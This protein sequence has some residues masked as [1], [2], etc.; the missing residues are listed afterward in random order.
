[1]DDY[2]L[3]EREMVDPSGP[4]PH[5][6]QGGS[7]S[8][9]PRPLKRKYRPRAS[10]ACELCRMK[11]AKCDQGQPCR[12]CRDR[13]VP[14]IYRSNS[15]KNF[16][17]VFDKGDLL[18][19]SE[20]SKQDP[21]AVSSVVRERNL[22]GPSQYQQSETFT[23]VQ[24]ESRA[25]IDHTTF[26]ESENETLLA[27]NH[28]NS[29]TEFYGSSSNFVSFNKLL[30]KARQLISKDSDMPTTAEIHSVDPGHFQVSSVDSLDSGTT[31]LQPTSIRTPGLT[32]TAAST[33]PSQ[34]P[35]SVVNLLCDE[36][37]ILPD[38]RPASPVT[39][40]GRALK[41][42]STAPVTP[43]T[44]PT[45]SLCESNAPQQAGTP[46]MQTRAE[47]AQVTAQN[48]SDCFFGNPML[49]E[50]EYVNLYFHNL[51]YVSPF[52]EREIFTARCER[53]IWASSALK[54]LRRNQMH[55]LALYNAVLAV[56]ALT[57]PTD[58]LE[59]GRAE[60]GAPW[61]EDHSNGRKG[62][63]SSIRLSKLY[64]QRARR[65]LGDVFEICSLESAQT[66]LLLSVYCQHALRPHASYMYSGM[67]VRTALAIGV[68]SPSSLQSA[69]TQVASS[70]TWWCI[71][72]HEI[73]INCSSGREITLG[74]PSD[75][76]LP[77]PSS[78]VFSST[79][80]LQS[81]EPSPTFIIFAQVSL[82]AIHRSASLKIYSMEAS[83]EQKSQSAQ[84]LERE[85]TTWKSKL[86][87]WLNPDVVTFKEPEWMS[88]QK[89][90]LEIRFHHIRAFLYRPFLSF[91]AT[92]VKCDHL[93][94]TCVMEAR[95]MIKILHSAFTHRHY[96]R[97]WWYN[98]T[99]V[100]NASTILLHAI[101]LDKSRILSGAGCCKADV[102]EDVNQALQILESMDQMVVA[103]RYAD[104]LRQILEVA[105]QSRSN[106]QNSQPADES[107]NWQNTRSTGS[108]EHPIA[109]QEAHSA[110]F[111]ENIISSQQRTATVQQPQNSI[112]SGE[113]VLASLIND[114]LSNSF[115]APA[116]DMIFG[117][118]EGWNVAGNLFSD[119]TFTG[120]N[121]DA[122]LW[123]W[124]HH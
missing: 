25:G 10:Q 97:S 48:S 36:T 69:E 117:A 56:G 110:K 78:N 46:L 38:P 59:N 122:S 47:V 2:G 32:Q 51:Y 120:E 108:D 79:T 55:F 111:G 103:V 67:A 23:L 19:S 115:E 11:K 20:S 54:R 27:V 84:Q 15:S 52:L 21:I 45:T 94:S 74:A 124:E 9:E 68:T 114:N 86:P 43:A 104:L 40:A 35:L 37:A 85:L 75:Y 3:D 12:I 100:V 61:E 13:D 92:T 99:H 39:V 65:L 44:I 90:E 96:I 64:F 121:N 70:K 8:H 105:E 73:N 81:N 113:D 18:L 24:D 109:S 41:Q 82:S 95:A 118:L 63:P 116:D 93:I 101:L 49:L 53:E 34:T 7:S 33:E 71:Y 57:T 87:Q 4:H 83:Y 1:M 42:G 60:L 28:Q 58:A 98:A 72:G 91:P 77:I 16:G 76:C 119:F 102:I 31:R 30:S 62:V 26:K 50:M 22:D 88:K 66:L 6:G 29:G 5:S 17:T 112:V 106:P 80:Q 123:D 14:C 107:H 89:L